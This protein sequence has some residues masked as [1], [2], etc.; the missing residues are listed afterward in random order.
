MASMMTVEILFVVEMFVVFF[1]CFIMGVIAYTKVK[2]MSFSSVSAALDIEYLL[3]KT[4]ASFAS[5]KKG[6]TNND[7]SFEPLLS[8]EGD[9]DPKSCC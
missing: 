6:T 1:V 2:R 5:S 4:K 7:G 3:V 8:S 9:S